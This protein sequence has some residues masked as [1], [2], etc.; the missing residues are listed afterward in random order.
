MF[1]KT[2]SRTPN[3]GSQTRGCGSI[4]E[5]GL[6][7]ERTPEELVAAGGRT[8]V[9]SGESTNLPPQRLLRLAPEAEVALAGS[10]GL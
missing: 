1:I 7:A 3:T 10:A 4:P 2:K 8:K 9:A 5:S 6:A